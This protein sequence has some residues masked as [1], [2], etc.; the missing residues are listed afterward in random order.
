MVLREN[1]GDSKFYARPSDDL[2][3]GGAELSQLIYGFYKNRLQAVRMKTKG[4]I[5][6][7]ALLEVLRQAYGRPH[8]PNQ[9]M[10]SYLWFGSKVTISY[11]K[12]AI[13]DDADVWFFSQPLLVEEEA[14]KKGKA[15]KGASGL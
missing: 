2:S 8:Q 12:N 11:N 7:Q 9:F 6:S 5:N 14:D 10:E 3:I 4:F 15:M 13:I 1:S